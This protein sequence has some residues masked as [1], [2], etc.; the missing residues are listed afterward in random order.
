MIDSTPPA[1]E[2]LQTLGRHSRLTALQGGAF[3]RAMAREALRPGPGAQRSGA[4]RV[5]G[6]HAP[7]EILRDESGV[8][9][10]F[11]R[12]A[13]DALFAL[14]FVHV[15]DRF[16]QME[17]CRRLAAGRIAEVVGPKGLPADRFM[18]HLGLHRSAAASWAATPDHI[19]DRILPYLEGI[20][21][22]MAAPP[23][24][25]EFRILDYEPEPWRP[26]D[27]TGW[28]KALAFFLSPGWD[29]QILRAR[30]VE[31]V[32]LEALLAIDRGYPPDGP[33]IAP[34]GAPYGALG[35]E[36]ETAFHDIARLIGVGA[37][38][39]GSN[40]WATAASRSAGGHALLAT[41]PHLAATLPCPTYF[42]H[43]HCP[44]WSVAGAT[45]PGLPG[46]IWGFNRRIA[47]GPTAGLAVTQEVYVEEFDAAGRR[48]RTPDGW[49]EA[50]VVEERIAVRGFPA[51]THAVVITRH[52]PVISPQLPGVRQA[53][54]LRSTVLEPWT[55][56]EGLLAL[57]DA[58]GVDA[59]R[60]AIAGFQEFNLCFAYADVDG[61]VGT[62][63]SGAV[64]RRRPGAGW[65]PAPGWDPAF[66]WDGFIPH[67]QL[68]HTFDPPD[69]R[70]WSANNAP[71]PAPEMTY[72][73]EFLDPYRAARIGQQL[74]TTAPASPEAC[75]ALQLDRCSLPML[76]FRDH[77]LAVS[78]QD[79]TERFLL[80]RVRDWDGAMEPSSTAAA[81]VGATVARLLE[82]VLR[83]KLGGAT[84]LF[85]SGG[86]ALPTVNPILARGASLIVSLLDETP[87]DWFGP[88]A[89]SVEGRAVW[90]AALTRAFRDAQA[91]LRDRLGKDPTRWTWGRCR[92]LTLSHGL[93]SAPLLSRWLNVGPF[94]YGSDANTLC[95]GGPLSTDPFAPITVI[96]VLRLVVEM[97]PEPR[98]EFA[99]AGA[100]SERR[101]DRRG[102]ALL[103]DW[104][105]GRYR[106]LRTDRGAIEAAG[107]E[108][109]LLQ[110]GA[111]G[112]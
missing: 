79:E 100:Q 87:Q 8:P 21:A 107:A 4:I 78:P 35:K 56:G 43:L 41:D 108:R 99:L 65:L 31:A 2:R 13:D 15:Q 50:E 17:Y 67:D 69:G 93:G 92:Q 47:W 66:D 34:P 45:V 97:A 40:N 98:A 44:E 11:A 112:R 61:H 62:Y 51:E 76:A 111:S 86:H 54:A 70:V 49:A 1:A 28:A 59:F 101:G 77:L 96:P 23:L 85:L 16:W 33:V 18:R 63:V 95:Q 26:Q 104:R 19:R 24:P 94:P 109:L 53:L 57:F 91:L 102:R 6:L 88:V 7:V 12:N 46:V 30:L 89:G 84:A 37:G 27:S 75:R 80:A 36:A 38:G 39:H 3:V 105:H 103:D 52:G 64:P 55:S 10:C 14:G 72:R 29:A 82:D 90:A 42:A 74:A 81:V 9:H 83:A 32:G 58:D 73:G 5:A 20:G 22:A 25:L 60:R 48:Y 110:P 71:R 68:P 106:L